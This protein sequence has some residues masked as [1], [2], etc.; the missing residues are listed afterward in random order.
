MNT[1]E[2]LID[3]VE[4]HYLKV[5]SKIEPKYIAESALLENM[6]SCTSPELIVSHPYPRHLVII[7]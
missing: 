3:K 2:D 6:V 5:E 1:W 7:Y 4:E